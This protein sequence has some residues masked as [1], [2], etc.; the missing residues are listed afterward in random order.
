MGARWLIGALAAAFLAAAPTF[1]AEDQTAAEERDTLSENEVLAEAERFF[2]GT[3]EGLAR[4]IEK[5]FKD[6][7]RPNGFIAGEEAS[8]AFIAGLRYGQGTLKLKAGG[9]RRVYWQGPSIGFDWG[10]DAAKVFTMVY[11][12]KNIDDIFQRF[13]GVDGSIYFVGGLGMNYQQSGDVILAPIRTGV[14]LRAGVNA[15]YLHYTREK[16]W[17]PF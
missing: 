9:K 13:P 17:N 6:H 3:S 8:G 5:A 15:G 12:L 11:H 10:G 14:G 2:G 16:S 1:A 4:I 7:G